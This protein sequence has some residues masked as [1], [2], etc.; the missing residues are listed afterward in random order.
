MDYIGILTGCVDLNPCPRPDEVHPLSIVSF[1]IST[2]SQPPAHHGDLSVNILYWEGD[3]SLI[4]FPQ[5]VPPA[6]N[7]AAWTIFLRDMT[8]ICQYFASQG[9]R[10]DAYELAA[11]L[12]TSHGYRITKKIDPRHLDPEEKEDRRLWEKQNIE[13]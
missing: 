13:K 9:V 2:C 4:D 6:S 11:D 5:V 10:R 12:W 8:R 7:P 1:A 3:I